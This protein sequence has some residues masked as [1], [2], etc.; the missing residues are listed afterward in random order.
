MLQSLG[1]PRGK[2]GGKVNKHFWPLLTNKII[3]FV[4]VLVRTKPYMHFE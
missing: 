1:M 3:L 4:H 2:W